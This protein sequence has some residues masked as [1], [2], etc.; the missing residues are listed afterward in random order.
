MLCDPFHRFYLEARGEAVITSEHGT[1]AA[2]SSHSHRLL[3]GW[4]WRAEQ[5]EIFLKKILIM[6]TIFGSIRSSGRVCFVCLSGPKLSRSL[7]LRLSG[8]DL[9]ATL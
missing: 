9:Q 1:A 7:H 4:S 3:S 2:Q 8:S 5:G 6:K